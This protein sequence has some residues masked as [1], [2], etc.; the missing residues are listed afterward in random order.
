MERVHLENLGVDGR[1]IFKW[2]F[3]NLDWGLDWVD[4][5]QHM[6]KR[7]AFVNAVLKLR[8]Q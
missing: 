3:N 2:I 7:W 1:I 6:D 8:V 4:L 5:A